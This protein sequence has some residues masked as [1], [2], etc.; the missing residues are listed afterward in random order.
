MNCKISSMVRYV[1]TFYNDPSDSLILS[2]QHTRLLVSLSI[3]YINFR[4][5]NAHLK[6]NVTA[7]RAFYRCTQKFE[8]KQTNTSSSPH[9]YTKEI[10][11]TKLF[12]FLTKSIMM[13]ADE[14]K[15]LRWYRWCHAE[16]Y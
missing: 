6:P 5:Y 13:F 8:K 1:N 7:R 9:T 4:D 11:L 15:F 3:C 12:T 2:Y 10:S 16:I 14:E